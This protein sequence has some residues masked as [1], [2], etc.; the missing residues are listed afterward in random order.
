M[1][2]LIASH[3]MSAGLPSE[4][5]A[6]AIVNAWHESSLNPSA[7]GDS[8]ASVGLF[9][10]HERGAG[11]GMSVEER[12]DPTIN[13]QRIIQEVQSSWGDQMRA[14]Y[15]AGDRRVSVFSSLFS[16]DIE[17]PADEVGQMNA[18]A[19]TALKFFPSDSVAAFKSYG[20]IILVGILGT[21][22]AAS[23][24]LRKRKS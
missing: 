12:M 7:V 9:Q 6:A 15:E 2:A 14:A 19:S 23:I 22:L 13:T 16:R 10:L 11:E 18:R 17:R 20:W 1:A 21:T 24:F 3:F 4:F 5:A 8:G